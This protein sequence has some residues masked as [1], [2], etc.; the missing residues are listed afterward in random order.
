MIELWSVPAFQLALL[1]NCPSKTWTIDRCT[2]SLVLTKKINSKALKNIAS[3]P[4]SM[5]FL[6]V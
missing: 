2:L 5:W 1:K 6:Q 3:N 4:I